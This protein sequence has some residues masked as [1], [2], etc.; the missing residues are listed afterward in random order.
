MIAKLQLE[1]PRAC[2][3]G[4]LEVLSLVL[5]G[6]ETTMWNGEEDQGRMSDQ[7]DDRGWWHL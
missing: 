3:E 2:E 4:F 1:D 7:H 5:M 6:R